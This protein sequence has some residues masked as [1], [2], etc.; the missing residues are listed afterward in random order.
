MAVTLVLGVSGFTLAANIGRD[1]KLRV[2]KRR[3]GA[4]ERLW[5]L[6]RPA[7]P[8][9]YP[10]DT[11]GRQQLHSSFTDWYYQNGD[12]MLLEQ[13]SRNV[14]FEA[15]DNLTRPVEEITPGESRER[16]SRLSGTDLEAERGRL[17]QRQLSL[18]RTQLKS[19]LAI[20]GRPYGPRLGEEDK[21]F[22]EHCHV[23][24]NRKPWREAADPHN[25][26]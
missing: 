4:Y 16:L 22:L 20:F 7:S 2:A 25:S 10:L 13:L 15:K 8:Y 6:M 24:I 17:A 5:A 9:S 26:A 23:D 11:D 1:L 3:L 18:L 21:A 12:G 19:D 14:Y